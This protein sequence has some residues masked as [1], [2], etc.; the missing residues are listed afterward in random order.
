MPGGCY[1]MGQTESEREQLLKEVSQGYY[2]IWYTNE[3]PRHEVCVDGFWMSKFEVTNEQYRR[4]KAGHDSKDSEGRSLNGG[5][6]PI[7]HVSWNDATAYA[8]WLS[9]KGNGTFRL[10]TEAE[11]EY[12]ARAGTTTVRY[13]GDDPD[14]ACEYANVADRTNKSDWSDR[15]VVP[16]C[17]DGYAVSA[18]VGSF[19]PN[20]FGL[21]DMM[22]NVWELC[23]DWY[24]KDAYSRHSRQNP[25]VSEAGSSRVERGGGWCF[26]PLRDV[27]S[28]IR[29]KGDPGEGYGCIGFRFLR[30]E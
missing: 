17:D 7:V 2:N 11:W 14:D 25:L 20:A 19:K 18:P 8:Q 9:G 27:R 22:G 1:Q 15:T 23:Q 29:R 28:A 26:F 30:V 13:W 5:S 21:Y 10:P 3:L 6:Q 16:D 24:A 12:A 4:Y